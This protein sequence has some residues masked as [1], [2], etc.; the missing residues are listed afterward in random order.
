[1][2]QPTRREMV[3]GFVPQQPLAD[4]LGIELTS[5]DDD[6]VAVLT[7][8]FAS[9]NVTI[10]DVVH[11]GAISALIDTAG[12]AAAWANDEPA[13]AGGGTISLNVDFAAPA[14]NTA[15]TARAEAYRRG[16]KTCFCA[17][18]VTDEAGDVVAKGLMTHRYA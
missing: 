11:G 13:G 10:G 1:M 3:R 18:T 7:M 4:H 2:S 14:R 16:R 5:I 6:D 8:P 12:M 15:L 17:V 9:H